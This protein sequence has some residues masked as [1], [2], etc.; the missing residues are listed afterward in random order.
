MKQI[1]SNLVTPVMLTGIPWFFQSAINLCNDVCTWL[2]VLSAALAVVLLIYNGIKW[3]SADQNEK[4]ME[5]KKIKSIFFGA[6]LVVCAEA[7]VKLVLSYF[8]AP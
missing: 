3:Y 6:V 7:I 8:S 5:M 1:T 4:P 2:I